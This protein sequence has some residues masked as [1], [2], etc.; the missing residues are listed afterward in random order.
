MT[1]IKIIFKVFILSLFITACDN[2]RSSSEKLCSSLVE[3]TVNCYSSVVGRIPAQNQIDEWE[4]NCR[5]NPHS[6][7]CLECAME[8]NCQDYIMNPDYV[9]SVL[10][11]N[12]CP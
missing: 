8:S 2:D 5:K 11:K 4:Q 3:F 1:K 12:D 6:A 9:Y 7:K 10:C